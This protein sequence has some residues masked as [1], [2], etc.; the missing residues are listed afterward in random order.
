MGA[1]AEEGRLLRIVV[2]VV[3]LRDGDGQALCHIPLVLRIQRV[4][5]ILRVAG[6]EDLPPVL[7]AHEERPGLVALG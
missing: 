7:G 4:L 5:I 1:P 2:G 6:H 3:V